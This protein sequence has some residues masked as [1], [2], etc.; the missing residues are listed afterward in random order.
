MIAIIGGG[1][2]G[3]VLAWHLEQAE[4]PYVLLEKNKNAGGCLHTIFKDGYHLEAGANSILANEKTLAF[5]DKL[6][7]TDALEE[8]AP[9]SAARFILKEGKIQE[10]PQ[11]PPKLLTN[12]FFSWATRWKI[13]KELWHK[14]PGPPNETIYSFFVRHFGEE[15]ADYA[16]NPFISGI[17][18][19]NP[20]KLLVRLTFPKL[21]EYEQKH[22]SVLRGFMKNKSAARRRSFNFKGGMQM[23]SIALAG[24]LQFLRTNH[25]VQ[26]ITKNDIDKWQLTVNANNQTETI[27]AD[28]VVLACPAPAAARLLQNTLP[29]ASAAFAQLSY[30]PMTVVWTAWQKK[31][32]AHPLAGFGALHPY[33]EKP[34]SAGSIWTQSVFNGRCPVNQ[35]LFTSFVG[36]SL[37]EKHARLPE[38]EIITKTA[39]EL[40]KLY[41]ISQLEPN[42]SYSY[43]W[44]QALPQYTA[45]AV[46]A[47]TYANQ[48]LPQLNMHVCANWIDGVSLQDCIDKG[49]ALANRLI[50]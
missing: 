17:Y 11:S 23:L 9:E 21:L 7:L 31:N 38:Q 19:G 13:I 27:T 24:E 10:L 1:I 32:V 3:L 41:G 18:A 12:S 22:G 14:Q 4:K 37:Y 40:R 45:A 6:K 47:A 44:P 43:K 8:A 16:L 33:V 42:F 30:A 36:G 20:K 2:S 39:E 50:S 35:V 46:P 48:T 29:E 25:E 15:V 26:Q 49:R 28:T 5:F 34:F